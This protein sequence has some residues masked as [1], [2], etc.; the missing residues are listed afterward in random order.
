MLRNVPENPGF[1][2]SLATLYLRE[3]S[4]PDTLIS[5]R[6]HYAKTNTYESGERVAISSPSL[7]TKPNI[8]KT[9]N[10]ISLKDIGRRTQGWNNNTP[11]PPKQHRK[12]CFE[13]VD[14]SQRRDYL[15]KCKSVSQR[16]AFT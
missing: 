11:T 16:L 10:D 3:N 7:E 12:G 5:K 13:V 8:V 1:L 15:S 14:S 2:R 9:R 4:D 6:N